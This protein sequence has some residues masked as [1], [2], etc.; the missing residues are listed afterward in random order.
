VAH[1]T[2]TLKKEM[3]A[4]MEPIH[5]FFI[6]SYGHNDGMKGWTPLECF[7]DAR[8]RSPEFLEKLTSALKLCGWE[9]D[10]PLEGMMLP[11]FFSSERDTRWF[12]VFHARQKSDGVSWIACE[13]PLS[14]E[15]LWIGKPV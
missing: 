15:N 10:G 7:E 6:Y 1:G 5:G 3:S 9:G 4:F 11:P 14:F 13:R 2:F 12:P 8:Y